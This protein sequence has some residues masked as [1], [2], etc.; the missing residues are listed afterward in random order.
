[1][2]RQTESMPT[3]KR[4]VALAGQVLGAGLAV[5]LAPP[6]QPAPAEQVRAASRFGEWL[7]TRAAEFLGAALRGRR[8]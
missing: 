3:S 5:A 2:M 4:W 6:G 8:K 1:M 7:A